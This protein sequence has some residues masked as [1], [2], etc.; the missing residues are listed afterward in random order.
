MKFYVL[1]A[2]DKLGEAVS[3]LSDAIELLSEIQPY[4]EQTTQLWEALETIQ[5]VLANEDFARGVEEEQRDFDLAADIAD[6][7][8]L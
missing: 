3:W 7:A 4:E 5:A 8:S 2:R 6:G 1:D